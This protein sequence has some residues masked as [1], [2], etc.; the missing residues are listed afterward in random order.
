MCRRDL[1]DPEPDGFC[2]VPLNKRHGYIIAALFIGS[3][4]YIAS[5]YSGWMD[6]WMEGG[7]IVLAYIQ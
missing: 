5:S 1:N 3:K 4:K 6:G 2:V 7:T